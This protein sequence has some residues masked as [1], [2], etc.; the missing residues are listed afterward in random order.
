MRKTYFWAFLVLAV[1]CGSIAIVCA[2]SLDLPRSKSGKDDAAKR[3]GSG[4]SDHQSAGPW[5]AHIS[6]RSALYVVQRVQRAYKLLADHRGTDSRLNAILDDLQAT[7]LGPIYRAHPELQQATAPISHSPNPIR[8]T[9]HDISR[10]TATRLTD[11]IT[12]IQRQM[13]KLGENDLEQYTHKNAAERALQPYL[14]ATAELSFARQVAFD[15]YPT[16]FAKLL[17]HLPDQLRTEESD[18]NYRKVTPP[19]GS[20]RLSD[21]AE[22]LIK[23]FM[24]DIHRWQPKADYIASIGWSMEQK[25]KGSGDE[26]W[27]DQGSG[28][29]LGAY[30]RMQIPPD[31]IHKIRD[32]EIVFTP[33]DP[34]SL[35]GKIIDVEN[36]KPIVRN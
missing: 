27:I 28:W 19:Q 32:I 5:C 23:S 33:E 10:A 36:H 20:I 12:R 2:A 9:P 1:I 21:S 11:D 35:A 7:V 25:S 16:L 30:S 26:N 24:Q 34:S 14:D 8:T 17:D 3:Y 13:S 31:L 4:R 15:A 6:R 29:I 22:A 18:K